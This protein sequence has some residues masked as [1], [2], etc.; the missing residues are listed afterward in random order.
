MDKS[1]PYVQINSIE[2]MNELLK[3]MVLQVTAKTLYEIIVLPITTRVVRHVKRREG[4]DA[5][6]TNISYNIFKIKEL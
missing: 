5:Y 4:V 2:A 6:D 1:Y 3:L